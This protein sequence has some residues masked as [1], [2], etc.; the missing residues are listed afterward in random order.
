MD[1][2]LFDT[3]NSLELAETLLSCDP[4]KIDDNLLVDCCQ[5]ICHSSTKTSTDSYCSVSNQVFCIAFTTDEIPKH[6]PLNRISSFRDLN[7]LDETEHKMIETYA[8][9]IYKDLTDIHRQAADIFIN[10]P[11]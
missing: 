10:Y 4:A 6:A 2:S 9:M 11:I 7:D 8:D 3:V 5:F 1:L